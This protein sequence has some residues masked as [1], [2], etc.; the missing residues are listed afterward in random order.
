ML[1][2]DN[3]L[4]RQSKEMR[5]NQI[6]VILHDALA[7]SG[8]DESHCRICFHSPVQHCSHSREFCESAHLSQPLLNPYLQTKSHRLVCH[9]VWTQSYLLLC[10]RY[11]S[12]LSPA[13]VRPRQMLSHISPRI[14]DRQSLTF[15]SQSSSDAPSSPL[16]SHQRMHN[17]ILL[18]VTNGRTLVISSSQSSTKAPSPSSLSHQQ[19]HSHLIHR[20]FVRRI[21]EQFTH[22]A[23]TF[24]LLLACLFPCPP[25]LE[26][27]DHHCKGLHQRLELYLICHLKL[28]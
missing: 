14:F 13:S 23:L 15:F 11:K 25:F 5:K 10:Q 7:P 8:T 22:I 18:S 1:A 19:T 28:A 12:T 6:L 27:T 9:R 2:T 20:V 17:Y 16:L 3:F 4:F 26:H 24:L 21:M